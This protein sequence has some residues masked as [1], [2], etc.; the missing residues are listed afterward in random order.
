MD[1][2]CHGFSVGRLLA[3]SCLSCVNCRLNQGFPTLNMYPFIISTDEHA[4][5]K[6]LMTKR[7]SKIKK[8]TEYLIE[9]YLKVL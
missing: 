2:R 5:L 4:S 7:L 8:S 1:K 3:A 6:F 9:L